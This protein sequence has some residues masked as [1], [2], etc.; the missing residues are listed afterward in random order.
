MK[1]TNLKKGLV[2]SIILLFIGVA[3][4]PSINFNVVK[5]TDD[6]DLV[7]LTSQACGI[8]GF[9]N[10]TVKLTRE[11]Y[12]NLEQY[13]VEFRA[14]LNQT[15]TREEAV[16]I[17]KEAVEELNM[18]GLLPKGMNVEQA[19]KLVTGMYQNNFKSTPLKKII[20]KYQDNSSDSINN[21]FCLVTGRANKLGYM[22]L[23]KKIIFFPGMAIYNLYWFFYLF[24]Y[25]FDY[26]SYQFLT[27]FFNRIINFFN[28]SLNFV[29]N[30]YSDYWFYLTYNKSFFLGCSIEFYESSGWI[31]TI[32]LNG[33]K[34][35]SGTLYGLT[36]YLI[37][38]LEETYYPQGIKYFVGLRI[39]DKYNYDFFIGSAFRVKIGLSPLYP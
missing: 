19:Q 24:H 11:Q 7:E 16:P 4:A 34:K 17:F 18:Y 30:I 35:I 14:R 33:I 5:A 29:T 20:D 37:R 31:H 9:G 38:L 12:Q 39:H 8:R 1:N 2:I 22:T 36:P 3:V 15:T 21:S 28:T 26:S 13:L 25:Y 10:T 27:E 23:I 6:N 32:G